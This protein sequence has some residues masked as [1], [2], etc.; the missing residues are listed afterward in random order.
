MKL[1]VRHIGVR[2]PVIFYGFFAFS[3]ILWPGG[4][5]YLNLRFMVTDAAAYMLKAAI[6]LRV[7]YP[8]LMHIICFAHGL[9]RVCEKLREQYPDVNGLI[10]NI[11]KIFVKAPTRVA[12]FKELLPN[13]ALPPE[14]VITRWA[15]WLKAVFY[16]QENFDVIKEV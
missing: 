7:F 4:I 13:T 11:K 14:P 3:E 12:R 10:S 9:N 2:I 8:N 16:Y 15:T 6:N 5:K 1:Y